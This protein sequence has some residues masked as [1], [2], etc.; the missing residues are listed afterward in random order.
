MTKQ[1]LADMFSVS[2]TTLNTNFPLFCKNQLKR[3]FLITREGIGQKANYTVERVE[4]QEVDKSVFSTRSTSTEELKGEE[5]KV[6][7]M[8]KSYEVSNFG[9]LR[10]KHSKVIQKGNINKNGYVDVSIE[11]Q[12]YCL[13]RL[14]LQTW[15]PIDNFEEMTV[16]HVNGIRTDNKIENL[17]WKS[18]EENVALMI[19][20]RGELNKELTRL[21]KKY[22]YEEV[23]VLLK[24][25]V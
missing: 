11:G 8:N 23:L 2:I 17:R 20:N 19:M 25:L 12:K 15:K 3:G 21:L 13:H 22:S 5:W 9:R 18:L 7:F 4:K 1:E 24:G 10:N 14:V 16:D 6:L